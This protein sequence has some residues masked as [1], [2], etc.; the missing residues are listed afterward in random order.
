MTHSIRYY[1]LTSL[2]IIFTEGILVWLFGRPAIHVGASGWIFGLWGL[3]TTV[4]LSS[5]CYHGKN[6]FQPKDIFLALFQG[7]LSLGSP[8]SGL[9]QAIS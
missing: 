4:G 6:T 8:K 1:V 2:F 3:F 5:V 7:L 9:S